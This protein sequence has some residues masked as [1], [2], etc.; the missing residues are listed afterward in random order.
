MLDNLF[1]YSIEER[2]TH[3]GK[4]Y[5]FRSYYNNA[6]G[7]WLTKQDAARKAGERHKALILAIHG[8]ALA[9]EVTE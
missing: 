2:T 7:T 9:G 1:F 6:V 8:R 5:R 3:W 4:E